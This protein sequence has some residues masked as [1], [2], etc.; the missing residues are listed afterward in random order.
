MSGQEMWWVTLGVGALVVAVVALLLSLVVSTAARIRGALE[1]V[2]VAGPGIADN[3]AHLDLLRRVNLVA[4]DILEG[5][6]KIAADAG[7]IQEHADGCAGCP[8]CVVGW[9]GGAADAWRGTE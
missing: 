3:T 1:Q 2:W 8:H 4:G 6:R 9:G 7:R 5:A